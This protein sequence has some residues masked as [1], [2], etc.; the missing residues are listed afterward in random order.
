MKKALVKIK[1]TKKVNVKKAKSVKRKVIRKRKFD[2]TKMVASGNDFIVFD[3]RRSGLKNGTELA[4]ALCNRVEAIG[5]DGLIFIE[6]SRKAD[7]K[8]RIFNPDGSEAE[9]C[10]NGMRC[11]ALYKGK[12]SATVETLAG[13]LKAE[14]KDDAIKV[15]MTPPKDMQLNMNLNIN[16]RMYPVNFVN[17]GVPHAIYFVEDLE[18]AK[19]LL[20]GR[21]IRYHRE[22]H[23][24][25][26]NVDFVSIVDQENLAIRT[27]ER[28][29]EAETLACGTGSVAS[30]LI[31]HHKFISTPGSFKIN[32]TTKSGEVLKIYFTYTG[33]EYEDVWMEGPARVVYEGE[34]YV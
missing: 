3:N 8:M 9:M 11:A 10:G 7:F 5:A 1:Q 34:C 18:L 20:L 2:F 24:E 19:V 29:V 17:T 26:T 31:H 28:G 13:I 15:K 25:G 30:A 12:K 16:G 6:K 14:L 33:S 21:L 23:P 4:A 32:I 22:F 27:Y